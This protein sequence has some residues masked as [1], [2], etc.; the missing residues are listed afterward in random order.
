M[1]EYLGALSGGYKPG[2]IRKTFIPNYGV[3]TYNSA[4]EV[5]KLDSE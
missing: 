4:E 3:V 5:K 1:Q 2:D